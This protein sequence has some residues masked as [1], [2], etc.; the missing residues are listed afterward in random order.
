M[1]PGSPAAA[2]ESAE[3]NAT[4]IALALGAFVIWGLLPIYWKIADFADAI[5]VLAHR[6]I[7]SVVFCLALTAV[8]GRLGLLWQALTTRALLLPLLLTT[9]IITFNWGLYIWAVTAEHV[10]ETSL[11]YFI[12]PLVN[13]ALGLIFLRERLTPWQWVAVGLATLGVINLTIAT[14]VLPW[15]SLCLA[16][17]FG[18]YGLL[19]KVLTV[20]PLTGLTVEVILMMVPSLI[21]LAW[22]LQV[23]ES[24]IPT[25]SAAQ[26]G[27][28]ALAGPVTAVPLLLFTAAARRLPYA[29]I[30]V[31]QYL[32][33]TCQFLLAILA[34]GEPFTSAHLITFGCVWAGLVIYTT[35]LWRRARRP[36][37]EPVVKTGMP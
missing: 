10:L 14:G 3:A 26:I 36:R 22:L 37:A 27:I 32:A 35:D 2:A 31:L 4:G 21:Y 8:R 9:V 5:E 19:R 24:I 15:I 34:F 20:G 29:T 6:A 12:N 11:G 7:W 1:A 17:S 16:F 33:P 13:V 18:F 30:G 28:L 23:G 25:A